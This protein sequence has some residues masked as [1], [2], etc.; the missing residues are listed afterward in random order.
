MQQHQMLA[1]V[2]VQALNLYVEQRVRLNADTGLFSDPARQ[3]GLVLLFDGAILR[4]KRRILRQRRQ[5]AERIQIV[6]PGTA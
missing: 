3:R 5:I 1:L 4:A 6:K 2:F